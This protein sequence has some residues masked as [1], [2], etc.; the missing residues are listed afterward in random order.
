VAYNKYQDLT[1]FTPFTA[2]PFRTQTIVAFALIATDIGNSPSDET[3]V[4]TIVNLD[5]LLLSILNIESVF[6]PG[7]KTMFSI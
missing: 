3:G 7:W 6:D 4:P 1:D 2:P 5:G